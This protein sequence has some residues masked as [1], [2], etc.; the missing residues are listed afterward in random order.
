MGGLNPPMHSKFRRA[1]TLIAM[2]L[3]SPILKLAERGTDTS[4]TPAQSLCVRFSY[5][6]P[7]LSFLNCALIL[8]EISAAK[9]MYL[10]V[11]RIQKTRIICIKTDLF[12][13]TGERGI[14]LFLS[15]GKGINYRFCG[16]HTMATHQLTLD[17]GIIFSRIGKIAQNNWYAPVKHHHELK[18]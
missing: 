2:S 14:C 15:N 4:K 16:N 8:S 17:L 13:L 7:I 9:P 18:G 5:F 10:P 1:N 3:V 12:G 6:I 11:F